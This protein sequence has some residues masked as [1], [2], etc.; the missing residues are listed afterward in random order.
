M[1]EIWA[2]IPGKD[3]EASNFGRIRSIDRYIAYSNGQRRFQAGKL[4]RQFT[5][6]NGYKTTHLGSKHM[7]N[8]VHRLVAL[9]FLG[10]PPAGMEVCHNNNNKSFN[11]LINL[12]HDTRK[13]NMDDR[14]IKW[15]RTVLG[16]VTHTSKKKRSSGVA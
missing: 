4:L 11:W 6:W 3:Y 2:K 9:A 12:R 1:H 7:N 13:G 14:P 5:L 10:P 16:D 15:T 8:Y